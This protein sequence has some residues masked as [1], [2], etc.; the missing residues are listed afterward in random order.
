MVMKHTM[1]LAPQLGAPDCGLIRDCRI[2][3]EE[4]PSNSTAL[5]DV[6]VP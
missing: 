6:L 3:C 4:H 2:E 1:E 5:K